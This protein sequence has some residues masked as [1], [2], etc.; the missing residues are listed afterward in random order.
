MIWQLKKNTTTHASWIIG[1]ILTS[2]G[3][4]W[5]ARTKRQIRFQPASQRIQM[6]ESS[7]IEDLLFKDR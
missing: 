3:C 4:G 2:D 5:P 1:C 6:P 7:A